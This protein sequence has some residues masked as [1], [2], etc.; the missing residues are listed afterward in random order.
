[1]KHMKKWKLYFMMLLSI[2][3]FCIPTTITF[4]EEAEEG[5]GEVTEAKKYTITFDTDGGSSIAAQTVEENKTVEKPSN[6][7][8][9][10]YEF[11]EWQLEGKT[12]DFTSKVEKDITLKAVWKEKQTPTK[13]YL[14]TLKI[15]GFDLDQNF[16]RT[17]TEYTT[18]VPSD[19]KTVKIVVTAGEN[20]TFSIPNG[21]TKTLKDGKNTFTVV[22]RSQN[23]GEDT[24]YTIVVTRK[25]P[26]VQLESLKVTGYTL[27]EKFD[28]DHFDY[29]L[30]VPND[31]TSINVIAK[32][33]NDRASV[34]VTGNEELQVGEN[35]V[36]VTVSYPTGTKQDYTITVTRLDEKEK[37][38]ENDEKKDEEKE[39][40]ITPVPSNKG[41]T[42]GGKKS[43]VI[44]IVIVCVL[45]FLLVGVGIFFYL[46]TE[47]P[48]HK[49]KR[50]DKKE[51]KQK[52]KLAVIE[53]PEE[54]LEEEEIPEEIESVEDE[55][56]QTIEAPVL[57]H[58][59]ILDGIEDLFD[60][61]KD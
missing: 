22:A 50:K 11:V 51:A 46:K 55:L 60:E 56:D 45:V 24:T 9:D 23:G 19:T 27:A 5:S 4:A 38:E 53:E 33:S 3:I 32:A 43:Q 25:V 1:M 35:K 34:K 52:K 17:N 30:E 54:L 31:I 12:Y 6:P 15:E 40:N 26:D 44:A 21:A 8:K 49:K 59:D 14:A 20:S 10:Q 18:T 7:T 58:S 28:S 29:T 57:D 2:G 42:G 13:G 39:N 48:E 41:T 61:D 37:E 16:V 47:T 36:V